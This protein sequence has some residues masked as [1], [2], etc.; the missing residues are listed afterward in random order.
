MNVYYAEEHAKFSQDLLQSGVDSIKLF[1]EK[2]GAYPWPELDVVSM[3]GWFGGME[4]PQLV[5]ISLPDSATPA[6]VRSVNAHEIGHQWFYGIIGNNEYDEAW[7]DESFATYSAALY[8]KEMDQLTAE[9]VPGY[10]LSSPVSDFTAHG[11]E[12][13]AAY[14]NM[15][16]DY[17]SRTL[18]DLR[19]LLGDEQFYASMQAYFKEKKFGITTTK[20]FIRIMEETSG[21]E[22]NPVCFYLDVSIPRR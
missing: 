7:L 17:G 6:W 14:Y 15:I 2:F 13:I 1:S 19:K 5:M 22:V 3:R 20:D 18:N 9:P 21:R 11:E 16:Y 10:H 4:Y 8:D 12:G